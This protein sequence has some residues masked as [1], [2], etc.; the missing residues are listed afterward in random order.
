MD[1]LVIITALLS[2]LIFL[3]ALFSIFAI[4]FLIGYKRQDKKIKNREMEFVTKEIHESDK[5]KKAKKEWRKFLEYDG[6]AP[7]EKI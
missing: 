6:S 2:V 3:L 7:Q 4:G 5:E 1:N